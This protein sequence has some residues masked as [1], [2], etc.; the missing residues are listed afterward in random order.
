MDL[1]TH[2]MRG[3]SD[4]LLDIKKNFDRTLIITDHPTDIS[5]D[6]L[7]NTQK[8]NESNITHAQFDTNDLLNITPGTFDLVLVM[9]VLHTA[10]DIQK[11][12]L[13]L[14]LALSPGGCMI[15]VFPGEDTLHELRDCL[16]RSEITISG[17][18]SPRVH[19]MMDGR[20]LAGL[21]QQVQ[22]N[23]PVVDTERIV[24]EYQDFY[25]LITDLRAVSATNIQTARPRAFTK[26][27][28]F[29]TARMTYATTADGLY[30]ATITLIYAIGWAAE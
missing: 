7:I 14:R 28:L 18:L 5:F 2:Y 25:S 1:Y 19:P 17:G 26:R 11:M 23:G 24:L 12:V 9:G 20:A 22:F 8:I 3:L 29:E 27:S 10:N 15:A 13:Q 30:P 4:R 16:A 6:P 21:M